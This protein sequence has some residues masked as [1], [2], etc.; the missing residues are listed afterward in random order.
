LLSLVASIKSSIAED[1]PSLVETSSPSEADK[2]SDSTS[3]SA[4]DETLSNLDV[5]EDVDNK[6]DTSSTSFTARYFDSRHFNSTSPVQDS[7]YQ[8]YQPAS[9][10]ERDGGHGESLT[11][12]TLWE[13][14]GNVAWKNEIDLES[15][16]TRDDFQ[17]TRHFGMV[18]SRQFMDKN[19][20]LWNRNPANENSGSSQKSKSKMK[21]LTKQLSFVKNQ[22]EEFEVKYEEANGY[23]PTQQNNKEVRNMIQQLKSL[24]RQIRTLR[25]S[26]DSGVNLD[27]SP[28]MS[29]TRPWSPSRTDFSNIL[30]VYSDTS[31]S[32]ENSLDSHDTLESRFNRVEKRLKE[33]EFELKKERQV[34]GRPESLEDMNPDQVLQEKNSIQLALNEAQTILNTLMNAS[35]EERSVLKEFLKDLLTRY[36]SVK[37]LVRRSSNVFIKDPCELETIPEGAEIQLTLASPQHRINIEMNS[38]PSRILDQTD[39]MPA[40]SSSNNSLPKDVTDETDNN[41]NEPNL[42]AM[43]RFELLDVQKVAKE[44]KKQLRK[45]LKEH[46]VKFLEVNGRPMPKDELKEHELYS[47]YKMTKAKLKLVDALLS[48][49]VKQ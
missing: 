10:W 20:G 15:E 38:S 19:Q 8:L 39:L 7:Q 23:R 36:R 31:G 48:K 47:K 41:A 37:R 34:S 42:H 43:S 30:N 35:E 22:I 45:C 12:A 21:Q 44:D 46:E 2:D 26:V 4:S 27:D 32:N 33:I 1:Q 49:S 5:L 9:P 14:H 40:R 29:P 6:S 18:N 13:P 25:D 3:S 24:K 16:E 17:S 11:P 28:S